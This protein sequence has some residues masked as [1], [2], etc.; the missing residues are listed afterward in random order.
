MSQTNPV[1]YYENKIYAVDLKPKS[2]RKIPKKYE[3]IYTIWARFNSLMD[4]QSYGARMVLLEKLSI[5]ENK[6]QTF[7]QSFFD[8][9]KTEKNI[10]LLHR[11]LEVL[12]DQMKKHTYKNFIYPL[13]TSL[14]DGF[15]FKDWKRNHTRRNRKIN[16]DQKIT[17]ELQ[18]AY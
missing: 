15:T 2:K 12:E 8:F 14:I 7:R 18:Q 3:D 9:E 4:N 13:D 1:R 10:S 17:G 6:F 16:G 11:L 5:S